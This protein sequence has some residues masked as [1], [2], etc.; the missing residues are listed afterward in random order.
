[1]EEWMGWDG[2]ADAHTCEWIDEW[3]EG[4][5]CMDGWNRTG[6]RINRWVCRVDK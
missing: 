5:I 2:R 3:E 1:M 6:G 4:W